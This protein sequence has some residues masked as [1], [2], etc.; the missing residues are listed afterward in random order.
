MGKIGR[1]VEC[2]IVPRPACAAGFSNFRRL[3]GRLTTGVAELKPRMTRMAPL[4]GE[5][6]PS[7]TNDPLLPGTS[8]QQSWLRPTD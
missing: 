2:R 8:L 1:N 5:T 7:S 6:K 4:M 3:R